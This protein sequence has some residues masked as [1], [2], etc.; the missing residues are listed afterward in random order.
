MICK[1]GVPSTLPGHVINGFSDVTE[2]NLT[3]PSSQAAN[4]YCSPNGLK[5]RDLTETWL[6]KSALYW[7]G[8]G[9]WSTCTDPWWTWP[10]PKPW[11]LDLVMF[12]QF[13]VCSE[14]SLWVSYQQKCPLDFQ[15]RLSFVRK[16]HHEPRHSFPRQFAPSWRFWHSPNAPAP[17]GHQNLEGSRAQSR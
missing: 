10:L 3:D 15:S 4:K 12:F 9:L 8:L 5:V 16:W 17:N 14:K 11:K 2:C 6:S 1:M 7:R 13:L